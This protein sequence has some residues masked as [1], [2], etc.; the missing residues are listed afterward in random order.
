[1]TSTNACLLR[2]NAPSGRCLESKQPVFVV[3]MKS[4]QITRLSWY[5]LPTYSISLVL[6]MVCAHLPLHQRNSHEIRARSNNLRNRD[7]VLRF[8]CC[9]EELSVICYH[10]TPI[11][12]RYHLL[13]SFLAVVYKKP[14]F[15]IRIHIPRLSV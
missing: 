15:G 9:Y 10:R 2:L 3:Q 13:P 4:N 1:M 12:L 11:I 14:D 8:L 7:L 5:F 6:V